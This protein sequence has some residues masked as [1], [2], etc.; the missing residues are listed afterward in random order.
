MYNT[1]VCS[2]AG[3]RVFCILGAL[4]ILYEKNK[5]EYPFIKLI[6]SSAGA[7]II[8]LI[9]IGYNIEEILNILLELDFSQFHEF[10]LDQLFLNYGF[11]HGKE[12]IKILEIMLEKKNIQSNITLQE[13]YTKTKNHIIITGTCLNTSST[14]YF[15]YKNNPDM[16]LLTALKITIS[17]PIYFT[18][19]TYKNKIYIDGAIL[20]H[21]PINLCDENDSKVIA[22]SLVRSKSYY[23]INNIYDYVMNLVNT[24]H[25]NIHSQIF[26][27]EKYKKTIELDPENDNSI[28]F[29]ISRKKK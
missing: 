7:V 16:P 17:V 18:S 25:D 3:T 12:I 15:D 24:V 19:V 14:E 28:E 9:S 21:C 20:N 6:G 1:I 23:E 27:N 11:N 26:K 13:H 4:K 2:G 10:Y 29:D 8:T 22:I 5:I